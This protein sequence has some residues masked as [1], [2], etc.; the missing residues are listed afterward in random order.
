VHLEITHP[1]HEAGSCDAVIPEQGGDAM[2]HCFLRP[3]SRDGAISGHVQDEQGRGI[4][5][6]RVDIAGPKSLIA[7][8]DLDGLFA[9]LDAPDGTYRLRI[10][11]N[12]FFP[13]VIELELKPRD[14]VL[15]QIILLPLTAAGGPR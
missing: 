12:G 15:P 5:G 2:V 3:E 8:T 1:G 7:Q 4:A 14:T 9:V 10:Q 6:A 11:A 13:Q